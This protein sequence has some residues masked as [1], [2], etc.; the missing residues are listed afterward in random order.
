MSGRSVALRKVLPAAAAA[1]LGLLSG[2]SLAPKSFRSMI[3]PAPIV[4]ARA[5]GLGENEPEWVAV[6][7]MI[8]RLNDA[9][10]VVRMTANEGLKKRTGQDFGFVP[11]DSAAD[12]G[13]SVA[14]WRS[15]WAERSKG[16]AAPAPSPQSPPTASAA[17]SARMQSPSPGEARRPRKW[18]ARRRRAAPE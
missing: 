11:W 18:F 17:K 7:A 12:R 6:P 8:E 4:R 5:V 16:Q 1:A 13:R 2:C 15:W 14:R 10:S 9:D 3:H